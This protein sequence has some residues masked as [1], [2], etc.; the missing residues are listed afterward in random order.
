[1]PLPMDSSTF[2]GAQSPSQARSCIIRRRIDNPEPK[3][4]GKQNSASNIMLSFFCA[5]FLLYHFILLNYT[6]SNS[7]IHR[8]YLTISSQ[9]I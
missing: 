4:R 1:M 5:F 2:Y 7:H 9:N 6:I 3:A 8:N